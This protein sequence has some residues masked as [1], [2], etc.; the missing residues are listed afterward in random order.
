MEFEN[1]QSA[2]VSAVADGKVIETGSIRLEGKS[3]V[4]MGIFQRDPC[5]FN[6]LIYTEKN[7]TL[8]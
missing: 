6:G 8:W 3:Q 1:F 2:T 5:C 7:I 4:G